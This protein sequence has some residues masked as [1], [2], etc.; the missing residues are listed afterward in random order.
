LEWSKPLGCKSILHVIGVN[1]LILKNDEMDKMMLQREKVNTTKSSSF[2]KPVIQKKLTVGSANDSYEAEADT[3]AN[4]VMRM[5]EPQQQNMSHSGSLVQRKC[6]GC[7]Q[8]EK[9]QMKPLADSITPLIQRRSTESGS[10]SH[11]PSHVESQINSSRGGGNSMDH[12]TQHFM[13]SRFGTDFSDVKIHTGSQA[14]QMSRELNAQAFTVGSDIYFNEGKY[15]PNSD[16]GRHL[17][18]HELTHT[19]QQTGGIGRKIQKTT[20]DKKCAVH[21][22]DNSNSKDTAVIPQKSFFDFSSYP[23]EIGVS[24]VDNMITKVNQYIDS[25]ENSCKCVSRLEIRGHG[26]DGYQSVGN[27]STYSN[28]GKALV[29]DSTPSHLEKLKTIKF[30][31]SG[32]LLLTG[33]HTGQGKGKILLQ[34]VSNI[35]PGILIGSAQHFT[36]GT[37][38]G[39]VKV[40]GDGDETTKEGT[41][42][43]TG[44][45]S[46]FINSPYVNWH[47]TI[48]GKEYTITGQDIKGAEGQSK[49]KS[50]GKVKVVTP[51]GDIIKIK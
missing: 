6:A 35:L 18:A 45:S 14:V 23:H 26:T 24:S 4:K 11:A 33:C 40:V 34:K 47:L 10:E 30:C 12:G 28:D 49:L 7:E 38:Y 32:M 43:D 37:G 1:F 16:S 13:E 3:V 20:K 44:K 51:E 25:T 31:D 41:V 5:Q 15:S 48:D 2:F 36:H 27:G 22:Y 39:G 8:E 21:A 9:L 17:L 50:A 46:D 29:H 19:V 42:K